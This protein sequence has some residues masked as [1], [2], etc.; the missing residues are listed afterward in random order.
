MPSLDDG[1]PMPDDRVTVAGVRAMRTTVGLFISAGLIV[2]VGAVGFLLLLAVVS[3]DSGPTSV[4]RAVQAWLVDQRTP[5]LTAVMS[6]TATVSGP[7]GMPI[8]VLITT[9]VWSLASRRLWRPLLLACAMVAGVILTLAFTHLVGRPRPPEE[10]ML[11]G[12]D[13]TYSFPSGHVVGVGDFLLV[14]GYLLCSR[15]W[16][17]ARIALCTIVAVAG[18]FWV[19]LCRLYLGYHWLTDVSASLGLS[20]VVL[21]L[22]IAVDTW[23][24][25]DGE[26]NPSGRS[27]GFGL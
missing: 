1:A 7:V 27:K 21:G 25:A 12:L 20:L 10:F 22:V 3:G 4:D 24:Q 8:I 14:G 16:S 9:V 5:A 15:A 19:A 17:A 11:M 23:C 2:L 26:R 6:V 13:P 18:I